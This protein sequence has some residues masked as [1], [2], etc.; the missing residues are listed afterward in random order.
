MASCVQFEIATAL[1]SHAAIP[2]PVSSV[3]RA[4]TRVAGHHFDDLCRPRR[5][6]RG[7][8]AKVALIRTL[9]PRMH[10]NRCLTSGPLR[11]AFL[12]SPAKLAP[13]RTVRAWI[14][15]NRERI[16]N[17]CQGLAFRI[18][19]HAVDLSL[20]TQPAALVPDVPLPTSSCAIKTESAR[21]GA[22]DGNERRGIGCVREEFGL[23]CSTR[24]MTFQ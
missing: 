15:V 23:T 18:A 20:P 16:G 10:R 3:R 2:V 21:T 13:F 9:W 6:Q 14:Q 1:H 22:V 19:S 17:V 24:Q 4:A 7:S 8:Y 5:I 11:K 12:P